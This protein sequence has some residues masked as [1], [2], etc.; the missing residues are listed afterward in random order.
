[1]RRTQRRTLDRRWGALVVTRKIRNGP[2]DSRLRAASGP[3]NSE[4]YL[5]FFFWLWIGMPMGE[6]AAAFLSSASF[7]N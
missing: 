2:E 4:D 3:L 1:M 6:W 7:T 5:L